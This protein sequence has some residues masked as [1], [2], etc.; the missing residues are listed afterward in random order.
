MQE[1]N[2]KAAYRR[3]PT[4][5][6]HRSAY[7]TLDEDASAP[8]IHIQRTIESIERKSSLDGK[9]LKLSKGHSLIALGAVLEH[10]SLMLTAGVPSL[11][12]EG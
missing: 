10:S 4:R 12:L 3:Q 1:I 7:R 2:S 5:A 8:T 9:L 6:F 11:S